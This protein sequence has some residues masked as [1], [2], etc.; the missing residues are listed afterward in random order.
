M[1]YLVTRLRYTHNFAI[2]QGLYPIILSTLLVLALFLSRAYLSREWIYRFLP[3]NLFLAWIPYLAGLA[4][5]YLHRRRPRCWQALLI[6]ALLWLAFFPNAPYLVT[7]LVHLDWYHPIPIWYDI[8]LLSAAAWTG[9]FL[10]VFSLR[11]MQQIVQSYAG[12]LFSWGFVGL[13]LGLTGVG[14]YLG[15]FLRW[16][17]W[18]LL[19]SPS[20]ILADIADVILPPN[21]RAIAFILQVAAFMLICYLTL[22]TVRPPTT[23]QSA[24]DY[25]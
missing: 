11:N 3:W 7:D 6:P 8:V 13:I 9:L 16:N 23:G 24:Q 14:V 1:N 10:A 5:A 17:S 2:E 20:H 18:D 22:T 21:L 25:Q 19:V 4:A 12:S 15:R